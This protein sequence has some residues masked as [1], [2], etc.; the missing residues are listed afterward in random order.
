M[1]FAQKYIKDEPKNNPYPCDNLKDFL[2]ESSSNKKEK[3]LQPYR[4]QMVENYLFIVPW[5]L[6]DG[7]IN[8]KP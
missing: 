1:I 2:S 5:Q 6:C 8:K 3:Q 7:L 4:F